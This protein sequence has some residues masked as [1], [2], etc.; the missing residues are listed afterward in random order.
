MSILKT[1]EYWGGILKI[2]L[3][4]NHK[5]SHLNDSNNIQDIIKKGEQETTIVLFVQDYKGNW[6][7]RYKEIS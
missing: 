3:A 4:M 5:T 2:I 7:F 6:T 1:R